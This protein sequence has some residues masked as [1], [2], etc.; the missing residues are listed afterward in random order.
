MVGLTIFYFFQCGNLLLY[1]F[2]VQVIGLAFQ[3]DA[4]DGNGQSYIH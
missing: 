1:E 2:L 4:F 3:I